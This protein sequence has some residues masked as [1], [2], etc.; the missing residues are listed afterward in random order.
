MLIKSIL[1]TTSVAWKFAAMNKETIF[2]YIV[3]A[4]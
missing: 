2:W 1:Q 4:L 3:I